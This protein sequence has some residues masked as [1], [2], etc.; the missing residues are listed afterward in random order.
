VLCLV[1]WVTVDAPDTLPLVLLADV[2]P[3]VA[4]TGADFPSTV[5]VPFLGVFA[6]VP[7]LPDTSVA[8]D[9]SPPAPLSLRAEY[10]AVPTDPRWPY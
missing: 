3:L 5:A 1:S 4:F 10:P 9:F 7:F 2:P 6:V 8:P